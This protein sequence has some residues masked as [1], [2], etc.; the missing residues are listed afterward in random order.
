MLSV[1][2]NHVLYG[3]MRIFVQLLTWLD[4]KVLLLLLKITEPL[5]EYYIQYIYVPQGQ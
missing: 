5:F 2:A 1:P 3:I 4:G